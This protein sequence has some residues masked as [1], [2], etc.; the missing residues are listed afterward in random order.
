MNSSWSK[1]KESAW[2]GVALTGSNSTA[3]IVYVPVSWKFNY[4]EN[5]IE[6]KPPP[7]NVVIK[8]LWRSTTYKCY[9]VV[10]S[11]IIIFYVVE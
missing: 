5:N 11:L 2:I 10:K 1:Q 9:C 6:I 8:F 7:K 4:S 3:K